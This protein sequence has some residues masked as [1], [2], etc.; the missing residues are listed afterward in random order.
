M[1]LEKIAL[2]YNCGSSQQAEG[3][4]NYY[5]AEHLYLS[6]TTSGHRSKRSEESSG[7]VVRPRVFLMTNTLEVGGSE[8]QFATLVES[9]NRERLEL[10]PA[11]LRRI[12]GLVERLGEIPEFSPGGRLFGIQAQRMQLA[13]MRSMRRRGITVAHAFDFYTNLMLIPAARMAGIPVI[14]SHRQLGDLLSSAKFT[15]QAWAFRLCHRVV[16]NS[17][18]SAQT[19]MAA[20]VPREKLEIIPNGLLEEAF[21]E[22]LPALPRTPGIVRIGMIARMNNPVKNHPAFLRAAAKLVRKYPVEFVLVG[23][24]PLRA[25]LEALAAELGIGEKIFFAGER[26]DIAAILASLDISVLISSSESLSNVIMESMAA[27]VAVVAT[28]VGGTPELLQDGGTG[29][30]VPAGD[31]S[32]LMAALARLVEDASLRRRLGEEARKFA[33][34]HFH[35]DQVCRRF[36]QLYQSLS[37]PQ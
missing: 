3:A 27:G 20:G 13:M 17:H 29:L 28:A 1:P 33:R 9:L 14:G 16:C 32:K 23:D 10:Y 37:K 5:A 21:A 22:Y 19:L 7:T 18:A 25:E 12:G 31:E 24:G 6:Q 35:I 26:H 36:E 34:A 4:V 30:L 11:C 2:F 15:A 8:R